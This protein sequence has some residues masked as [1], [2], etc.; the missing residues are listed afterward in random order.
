MNRKFNASSPD[1]HKYTF[2]NKNPIRIF[3][4]LSIC[5][6]PKIPDMEKINQEI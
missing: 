2:L 1:P 4:L 3:I 5:S 6:G